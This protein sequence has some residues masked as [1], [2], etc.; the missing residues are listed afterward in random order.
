MVAENYGNVLVGH[1]PVAVAWAIP[2][3][4]IIRPTQL[5]PVVSDP[6]R[7]FGERNWIRRPRGQLGYF[8]P[9]SLAF[10]SSDSHPGTVYIFLVYLGGWRIKT[11]PLGDEA[12]SALSQ[13]NAPGEWKKCK[14]RPSLNPVAEEEAEAQKVLKQLDQSL[15][16][17][18]TLQVSGQDSN[19][20]LKH[21]ASGYL[22][23]VLGSWHCSGTS[24]VVSTG[25]SCGPT[26]LVYYEEP[27]QKWT[28]VIFEVLGTHP[29]WHLSHHGRDF[30]QFPY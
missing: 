1:G 25:Y 2:G 20:E 10:K 29:E 28:S 22:S 15:L 14:E 12:F 13:D 3:L 6:E 9:P 11:T 27:H 30:S 19:P 18:A 26:S 23:S 24:W 16:E 21:L 7:L 4:R 8:H 17:V 5:I